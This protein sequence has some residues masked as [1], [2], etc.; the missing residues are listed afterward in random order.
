MSS[1]YRWVM[2]EPGQPMEKVYFELEQPGAGEV[3]VE[4]AG[5]GVCH[6]DLGYFYDGVRTNHQLPLALGHEISGRVIAAGSGSE[7]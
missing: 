3:T 6:T 1:S 5:C 4:V 7:S 2:N